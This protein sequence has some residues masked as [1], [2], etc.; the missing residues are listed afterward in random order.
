MTVLKLYF[1]HH[2]FKSAFH[3]ASATFKPRIKMSKYAPLAAHL[4]SLN[5]SSTKL[6]FPEVEKIIGDK[7]PPSAYKHSVWWS[8]S[9]R[10]ANGWSNLWKRAGWVRH[11]YSLPERWVTFVRPEHYDADSQ[12]AREGYERDH[13]ILSRARNAIL[14]GKRKELDQYTCQVCGFLL[15]FNG[16]YVIDVHHLKLL[17]ATRETITGI[18]DLISLCPTCHRIAH[19]RNPPYDVDELKSIRAAN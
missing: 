2:P 6:T 7:L 3:T 13:Q 11:S 12:Q 18:Q 17:S 9:D 14:A 15:K 4:F 1:F 8:N 5:A 16:K 19:L 10:G